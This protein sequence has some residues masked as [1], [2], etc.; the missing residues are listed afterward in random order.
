[1]RES[2]EIA[3]NEVFV[4]LYCSTWFLKSIIWYIV[5]AKAIIFPSGLGA[6]CSQFFPTIGLYKLISTIVC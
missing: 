6:L 1:M 4:I 5:T 2:F 3:T